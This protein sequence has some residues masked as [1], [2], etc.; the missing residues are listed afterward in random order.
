MDP[1]KTETTINLWKAVGLFRILYGTDVVP[2]DPGTYQ[3]LE[4]VQLS[5]GKSILGIRQGSAEEIVATD[6][7]LKTNKI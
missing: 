7:G 1:D 3:D 2:L 4:K 5:M 6:L